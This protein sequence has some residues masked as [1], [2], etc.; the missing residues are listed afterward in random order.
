MPTQGKCVS[1]P[2]RISDPVTTLKKRPC[3]IYQ[4]LQFSP[5][6]KLRYLVF[7]NYYCAW[8]T[9][10]GKAVGTDG[11]EFWKTLLHEHLLMKDPHYEDDAQD[12]HRIPLYQNMERIFES[13]VLNIKTLRV[14][15]FQPSPC[16]RNFGLRHIICYS[17]KRVLSSDDADT[18]ADDDE[19]LDPIRQGAISVSRLLHTC[20]SIHDT[21]ETAERNMCSPSFLDEQATVELSSVRLADPLDDLSSSPREQTT[22][23][24]TFNARPCPG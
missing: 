17:V 15:L 2:F 21:F 18:N 12:W 11:N 3:R 24:G 10:K 13:E 19:T 6:A 7:R 14:Y 23:V 1:I 22:M 9:V 5:P 4:D 20:A 8:I 16:W